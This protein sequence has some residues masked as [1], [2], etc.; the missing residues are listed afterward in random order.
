M[1]KHRSL[2]RFIGIPVILTLAMTFLTGIHPAL[3]DGPASTAAPDGSTP[4][5]F[6]SYGHVLA[7]SEDSVI[8][9]SAS[10]MLKMEFVNSNPTAPQADNNGSGGTGN[11]MAAPITKVTYNNL[12]DNVTLV[13]QASEVAVV[14]STYYLDPAKE[15]VNVGSIR[16]RY[17]RPVSIDGQGNLVIAYSDGNVMESAPIAW[18]ETG[19]SRNPVSVSWVLY[20]GNEVGF[21]LGDYLP[22]IPVVID[23]WLTF[24]GGSGS[25]Y[26]G[27]GIAHA[28]LVAEFPCFSSR[29]GFFEHR[30]DLFFRV[31]LANH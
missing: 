6:T 15:G 8:I 25:D 1:A 5:Q 19:S 26:G 11:G 30:D 3:A 29:L 21:S 16:L 4:L 23:P 2:T 12:C 9:A 7:F 27:R 31:F 13:Y 28:V 22:G 20:G 14:L 24:L 17:N 18:Q 10:Q